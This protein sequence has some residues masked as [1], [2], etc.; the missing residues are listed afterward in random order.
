MFFCELISLN[1]TLDADS[2]I[3]SIALSGKN[4]SVIYLIDKS[5]AATMASYVIFTLWWD[6]YFSLN[7]SSIFIVS[8]FV[9]S[10]IKTGWNLLSNAE[11]FSI[12]FLYS[13]IVVAPIIC[14]SP[15]DSTGFNILDASIVLS[16]VDPAPIIV[17]NS[18][19]NKIIFPFLT[20]SSTTCFILSSN[21]PLYFAPANIDPISKVYKTFPIRLSGTFP[22]AIFAANPSATDVFP[23]PGSPINTGLFFVLLLNICIALSISFSL[24]ITGSILFWLATRV[25]FFPYLSNIFKDVCV[26][27]G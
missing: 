21:S 15:L 22:L 24:P 11:S 9:G 13:S 26:L 1:L 3:K 6:S 16:P 20:T 25:K 2:S 23:T 17:C 19:I 7:P 12:C 14:I 4:L 10:V 27:V 5:T 18:S 8:S